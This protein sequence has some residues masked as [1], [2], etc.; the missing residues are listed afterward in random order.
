MPPLSMFLSSHR[1]FIGFGMMSF[2]LPWTKFSNQAEHSLTG[3]TVQ[4]FFTGQ[5]M[6]MRLIRFLVM[7][8]DMPFMFPET[9]S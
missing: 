2:G 6:I 7:Y 1:Q 8:A 4:P 5:M 3:D 9:E